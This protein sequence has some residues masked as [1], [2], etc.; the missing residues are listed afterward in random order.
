[1]TLQK[2]INELNYIIH[3]H[4]FWKVCIYPIHFLFH[5]LLELYIAVEAPILVIQ[6][7]KLLCETA[8]LHSDQLTVKNHVNIKFLIMKQYDQILDNN[9]IF[10]Q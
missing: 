1:M 9:L 2:E 6:Q 10:E 7:Y 8:D 3:F 4:H 5:P